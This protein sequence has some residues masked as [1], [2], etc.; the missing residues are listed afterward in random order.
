C[1]VSGLGRHGQSLL[2]VSRREGKVALRLAAEPQV[3]ERDEE[4]ELVL[5]PAGHGQAGGEQ[6]RRSIVIALGEPDLP[7]EVIR[8]GDGQEVLKMVVPGEVLVA[9]HLY[10]VTGTL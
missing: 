9:E 8:K 7:E 10:Q 4:R 5:C 6:P 3:I 1:F 2:Q